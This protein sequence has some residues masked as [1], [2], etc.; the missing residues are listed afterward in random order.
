MNGFSEKYDL[1]TRKT[2]SHFKHVLG[3]R[4]DFTTYS[5]VVSRTRELIDG[6]QSAYVCVAN[7]HMI[8]EAYDDSRF[9]KIINN[10]D[11][12]TPDGMP[13][14]WGLKLLGCK[15]A[16]RVYGPKLTLE[17]CAAC[18]KSGI[19]VGFYGGS[20]EVMESLLQHLTKSFP[21]LDVVYSACPPYRTLTADEDRE[22]IA[23][24]VKSGAEVL[25][26]GL[27]CP[28]QEKWMA[29]HIDALRLVMI[30]VG[31]AFDFISRAK[32]QAPHWMQ[33]CGLEWLFRLI[34]EPKRLWK[35]YLLNNPRF[36]F[37]F[38]IQLFSTIFKRKGIEIG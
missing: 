4:V 36:I 27:G 20:A 15:N 6:G 38:L 10:A 19:P 23:N 31:A 28:K 9:Q 17:L 21:S 34:S 18:A 3:M 33:T 29:E 12:V 7:V 14:V 37:H 2:M 24:I 16:E 32:P 11:I 5:Q 25:F 8:M 26:V 35:R 22:A 13:L 1:G 30:G